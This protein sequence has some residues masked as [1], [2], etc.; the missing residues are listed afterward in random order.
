MFLG[1]E[2]VMDRP[3]MKVW[4]RPIFDG[5]LYQYKVYG[6]WDDVPAAAFYLIQG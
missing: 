5:E 3:Q 6:T 4:R 1:W 2:P